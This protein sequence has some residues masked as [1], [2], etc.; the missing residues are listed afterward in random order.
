ML[1][2]VKWLSDGHK[3]IFELDLENQPCQLFFFNAFYH[4][5]FLYKKVV[6]FKNVIYFENWSALVTGEVLHAIRQ[7]YE[8]I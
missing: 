2:K 7:F 4:I 1:G 5:S 8:E 6:I 3:L